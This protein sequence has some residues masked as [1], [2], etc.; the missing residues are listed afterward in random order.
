MT[1]FTNF[2]EPSRKRKK[3]PPDQLPRTTQLI[4]ELLPKCCAARLYTYHLTVGDSE[5][6]LIE[7]RTVGRQLQALGFEVYSG[8]ADLTIFWHNVKDLDTVAGDMFKHSAGAE[9]TLNPSYANNLD[10]E[11][12]FRSKQGKTHTVAANCPVYLQR[13]LLEK[14]YILSRV[15][16][17]PSTVSIA[18]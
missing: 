14:R 6:A 12:R 3:L 8:G 16:H 11:I 7:L 15:W 4:K 13:E 18:W 5:E 9:I 2:I 10:A 17:F 1:N